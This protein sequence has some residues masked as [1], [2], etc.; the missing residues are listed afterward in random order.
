MTN[1]AVFQLLDQC[2]DFLT[3][4]RRQE[5]LSSAT[6]RSL[7]K[8]DILGVI[9]EFVRHRVEERTRSDWPRPGTAAPLPGVVIPK[10]NDNSS[11]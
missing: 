8:G 6:D 7:S 2:S 10:A 5:L 9:A 1:G 3:D 11:K 4:L